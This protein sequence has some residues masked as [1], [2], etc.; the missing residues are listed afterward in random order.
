MSFILGEQRDA[1][2]VQAF[3]RYRQYVESERDRFP[4][5]ALFLATSEWYFNPED[6]RCPHDAWLQHYVVQETGR[7][8]RYQHRAV[9]LSIQL[10]GG[11]HDLILTFTYAQVHRYDFPGG[12]VPKGHGDWRYDEFRLT[13]EGRLLHEIEWHRDGETLLWQVE[14]QDVTFAWSAFARGV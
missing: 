8:E 5:G 1:D 4:P 3:A 12:D 9:G 11:Y 2:I 13:E 14:A 10:L 7:G 6:H